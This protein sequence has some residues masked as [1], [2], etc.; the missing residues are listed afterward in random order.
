MIEISEFNPWIVRL[1][2]A[3]LVFSALSDYY[4]V[5]YFAN[6]S[7]NGAIGSTVPRFS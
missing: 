2:P 1:D 7:N 6:D 4:L 3:K 5:I